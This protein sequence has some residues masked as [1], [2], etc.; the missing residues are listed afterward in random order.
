METIIELC[1]EIVPILLT[2]VITFFITK[3]THNR[4]APL[5]KM[6]IA[7]RR[8]Y[9]PLY[10]MLRGKKYSEINQEELR[11]KMDKLL[12]KYDKYVSQSTRL[13]YE[14]Y[15]KCVDAKKV[16]KKHLEKFQSNI[17]E[18]NSKLRYILGYPQSS[19]WE[20]YIYLNKRNKRLIN[21]CACAVI[22]YVLAILQE[23]AQWNTASYF[24]VLP[25]LYICGV[26]IACI[27]EG[28]VEIVVKA[29]KV[30][31]EK[32]EEGMLLGKRYCKPIWDKVVSVYQNIQKKRNRGL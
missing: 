28:F 7:Y 24:A 19:M 6:E 10:R 18:Y 22:I 26:F 29:C 21:I 9:Y 13:T 14:D 30:L 17:V 1:K 25:I 27:W 15:V 3:Y 5:D 23:Y 2:G 32:L 12:V 11:T 8:I 4:S 16:S 31:K 20:V